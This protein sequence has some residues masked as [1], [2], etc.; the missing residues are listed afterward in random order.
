M[1]NLARDVECGIV[2]P[3]RKLAR[4]Y[5]EHPPSSDQVA[6]T[7]SLFAHYAQER[8]RSVNTHIPSEFWA[9]TEVLRAMA[10]YLREPLFVFDVDAK[11]DAHVQR[12]YYKNYSLAYGGDHESGCGGVMYDLT[13]KDMLKH[14]TRLHILVML[15]KRHEGHFYGVH[16]RE[17]STRWL[18]EEDREFADANCSSH[19]WHA[20]VV[21]HIDYSAGR[22]HAVDPKMI[23]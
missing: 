1:T 6:A 5:P 11:N 8:A 14:Y 7:T 15:I 21:A 20:N 16:H 22:I 10:Q 19:A 13:A 4:L 9:G 2:D 23:T 3:T 18:A 17:I 12:Y